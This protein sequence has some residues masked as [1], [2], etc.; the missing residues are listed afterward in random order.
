MDFIIHIS[1]RSFLANLLK[2]Y[3]HEAKHGNVSPDLNRI[4]FAVFVNTVLKRLRQNGFKVL[5]APPLPAH[6]QTQTHT[7][8]HT[9]NHTSHRFPSWRT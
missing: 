2:D 8:T 7:R 5:P 4:P 3:Q 9:H 6:T 1:S